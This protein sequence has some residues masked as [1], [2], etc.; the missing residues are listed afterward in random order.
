M[1]RAHLLATTALALGA[2]TSAAHAQTTPPQTTPLQ[3]TPLQTTPA[4][5]TPP[6]AAPAD[7]IT[8]AP[9]TATG[10]ATSP[11]TT[12]P[13]VG[14]QPDNVSIS[15][16]ITRYALPQTRESIG[17]DQ[18]EQT[19]NAIDTEDAVKYLPSIFVRKRNYGDT[20]PTLETRDW[21]VN[22]SARSLVFVDDVPISA[23]IA[24]NNTNGAPRWGMVSLE[25]VSGIDMLYGPFAA[26]YPGNSMGGVMLISTQMPDH[27]VM[28]A[29]QTLA[30]QSFDYYK[31]HESF[32]TSQT[33]ATIG[34]KDGKVSWF[35][36][37]SIQDSFSQPL[38]FITNSTIPKGTAGT[39]AA[40]SKVGA[41]ANVVGAGGLLH[42]TESSLTGKVAVDLT[43]WLRATYSVGYW[44]NEAQS[45]TQSYLTDTS[46]NPTFGGV[47]GFASNTYSLSEQHL[48]NAISLKTDTRDA[49]DFEVVATRYDYL[50]DI[51]NSPSTVTSTGEGF[52]AA[53]YV[54]RLDGTGWSTQDA[55]GIWRPDGP[56]GAHEISF[57]VHRDEYV[58]ENPTYNATT[59]YAAPASG[60]GTVYTNGAET[61]RRRPRGKL[62]GVRRLQS[63]GQHGRESAA[64]EPVEFFAEGANRLAAGA[65][66]HQHGFVRPGLSL[67]DGIG[68][69]PDRFDRFGVYHP[70][71]QFA[72]GERP[73]I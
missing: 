57:G 34:D 20:Q 11:A 23:L 3:T 27:L 33:A 12:A 44:S 72:A 2:L 71:R 8:L 7:T 38:A 18:I 43:D 64:G 9:V 41:V 10:S 48:M 21:G 50:Q 39:I 68:T 17:A 53:G 22:S 15:P 63:L 55:K 40:L 66:C 37:A 13:T 35:L 60:N 24:N 28:T 5:T 16:N 4:Q 47:A 58:L 32:G 1:L 30:S 29:K 45:K 56:G 14:L 73:A 51:Q 54:A 62:D 49:W 67:P 19:T 52:K 36:S 69:L 42:T 25:S 59:W 65:G 70:Q 31:T 6:A 61:H 46:G 26:E